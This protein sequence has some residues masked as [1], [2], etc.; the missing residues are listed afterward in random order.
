ML[1]LWSILSSLVGLSLADITTMTDK[2]I[3]VFY[4]VYFC[5]ILY[6]SQ[7]LFGQIIIVAHC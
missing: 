7:V 4:F 2:I 5:M 6:D 3:K 1:L